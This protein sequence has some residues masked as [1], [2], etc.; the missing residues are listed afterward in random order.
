MIVVVDYKVCNL[1]S[2]VSKLRRLKIEVVASSDPGIIADAQKLIL[3]G[4]GHFASGMQNL[5]N[6]GL[7][8][9]LEQK[10][11]DEAT[12]VL[13]ICL[14]MQLFAR[15]SEEG[16]AAGLGWLDATVTRFCFDGEPANLRVPHVAWNTIDIRRRSWMLADLP[17][18]PRFY[19]T[20]SF[21]VSCS[22]DGDVVATTDY[23]MSFPSIV[24]HGNIFG[25]Q[26]HPEKSHQAGMR[27]L[28]NFCRHNGEH[29][30]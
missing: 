28:E 16:D 29:R 4:V 26:F 2:I 14:G 13:G 1:N 20:H 21:F 3:P 10:V 27:I 8:R 24:Q 11:L 23:G 12:P 7:I 25:T 30:S 19:F 9:P 18:A 15:H 17:P 6:L 22:D 5:V